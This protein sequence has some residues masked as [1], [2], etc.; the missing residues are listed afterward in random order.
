MTVVGS[1]RQNLGGHVLG[2]STRQPITVDVQHFGYADNLCGGG[3]SQPRA[4][5]RHKHMDLA[6]TL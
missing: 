2:Q 4:G 1:Q 5:T 3:S 6:T